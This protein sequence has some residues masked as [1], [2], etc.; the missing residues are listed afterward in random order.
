MDAV[1]DIEC[2]FCGCCDGLVSEGKGP[3]A[4]RVDC[5]GCGK[6]NK[7]A[8]AIDI[9]EMTDEELAG[10]INETEWIMITSA[11]ESMPDFYGHANKL[12]KLISKTHARI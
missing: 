8:S 7:W 5:K 12:E 1:F 9:E 3:H 11:R 2:K 6:F 10:Q 4:Y